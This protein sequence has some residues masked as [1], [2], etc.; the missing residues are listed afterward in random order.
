MKD[1]IDAEEF[2]SLVSQALADLPEDLA[3]RM[4]NVQV[5]VESAPDQDLA[6][7]LGIGV[8]GL[9]G[10][11]QGVPLTNRENYY[12][13]LPDRITLYRDNITRIARDAKDL[14]A[15]VKKTVIHEVAHHFGIDDS[16]LEELGWA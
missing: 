1:E 16:R 9:L 10:L 12:W 6:D 8:D 7:E 5:V 11:Y 3:E 14:R 4:S 2:E 15:I 13:V